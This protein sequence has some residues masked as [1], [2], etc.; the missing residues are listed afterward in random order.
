MH[1]CINSA[2]NYMK[3]VVFLVVKH[4]WFKPKCRWF[5]T[6]AYLLTEESKFHR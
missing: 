2:Y 4:C 3:Y 5:K 6:N 1:K